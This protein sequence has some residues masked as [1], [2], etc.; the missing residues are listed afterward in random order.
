MGK[1]YF[2]QAFKLSFKNWVM[3]L[4]FVIT[5]QIPF[6]FE[7]ECEPPNDLCTAE[8]PFGCSEFFVPFL[9]KMAEWQFGQTFQNK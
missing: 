6:A 3:A 2:R 9:L 8:L 7:F 4:I 1:I 5:F